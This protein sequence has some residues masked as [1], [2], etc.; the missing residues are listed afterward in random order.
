MNL[1]PCSNADVR[2][3]EV[4]SLLGQLL[5]SLFGTLRLFMREALGGIF[6]QVACAGERHMS[7][8]YEFQQRRRCNQARYI[9]Q[10]VSSR[11]T[12]YTSSRSAEELSSTRS[13]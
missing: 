7:M 8:E 10:N 6:D 2:R 3:I 1:L 11:D 4:R 9:S 12:G 5:A 13:P